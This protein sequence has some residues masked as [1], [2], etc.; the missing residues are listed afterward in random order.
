MSASVRDLGPFKQST[1]YA[2][3]ADRELAPLGALNTSEPPTRTE[4][5][6]ST[7]SPHIGR[8]IPTAPLEPI[9]VTPPLRRRLPS[10]R[11]ASRP[12]AAGRTR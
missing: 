12:G 6:T 4:V 5:A 3:V 2:G 10:P 8:D 11:V 9:I 7:P 1:A